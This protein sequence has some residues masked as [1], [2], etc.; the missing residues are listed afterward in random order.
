MA[1]RNGLHYETYINSTAWERRRGL[2]FTKHPKVCVTC[3]SEEKIQLH[4]KTYDRMGR[5]RDSD[6]MALCEFCHSTLHR[7]HREVGGSLYEASEDFVDQFRE[8]SP[9]KRRETPTTETEFVPKHLRG[10]KRDD[11]GRLLSNSDWR[12]EVRTIR[13]DLP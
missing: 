13:T 11:H 2:F 10:A 6:L 12:R 7:W 4:H 3:G 9:P 5:E 1:V 8:Q